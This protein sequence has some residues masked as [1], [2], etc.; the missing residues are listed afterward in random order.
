MYTLAVGVVSIL[1]AAGPLQAQEETTAEGPET[2]ES[3][4]A[5][6]QRPDWVTPS[7]GDPAAE[8]AVREPEWV[9]NAPAPAERT[10]PDDAELHFL[11]RE[12]TTGTSSQRIQ[13][14]RRI[15]ALVRN[16]RFSSS[17][18]ELIALLRRVALAQLLVDRRGAPAAGYP[19]ARLHAVRALAHMSGPDVRATLLKVLGS[20][21]EPAVLAAAM[22]SLA[23]IKTFPD[24]QFSRAVV[25]MIRRV[26]PEQ[27]NGG[28]GLA[29]LDSL[30]ELDDVGPGIQHAP[31][32]RELIQLAL[33]A[34]NRNVKSRAYELLEVLREKGSSKRSD[35]ETGRG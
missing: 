23:Q 1:L 12:V 28:L 21:D 13:S 20:E 4:S 7:T 24:E 17:D 32:Y 25:A 3:E 19:M 8:E 26:P 31:L 5:A 18:P 14:V 15:E 34:T 10:L 30:H 33:H 6:E 11:A 29:V 2:P 22:R 27:L 35:T 9:P 16:G